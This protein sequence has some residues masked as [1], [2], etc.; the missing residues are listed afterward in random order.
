MTSQALPT[1]A[2]LNQLLDKTAN[3]MNPAQAQGFICGLL[4]RQSEH[5]SGWE[6]LITGE[7]QAAPI[8]DALRSFMKATAKQLSDFTFDFQLILPEDETDLSFRAE[9]LTLWCQG[10]LS[11]MK[12]AEVP[13]TGHT[14]S[15]VTEAIQ[16]IVE[17]AKMRYEEV[18]DNEEDEAAYT[19]LVE[20]VRMAVILIYQE[21]NGRE[22]TTHSSSKSLH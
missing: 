18:V 16:D 14:S 12:T 5:T 7:D 11:G 15:D 20:F 10:F 4:L 3:K 1:F 8:A 19:E 22:G 9:S 13:L 2:D 6:H 21:L 17:I